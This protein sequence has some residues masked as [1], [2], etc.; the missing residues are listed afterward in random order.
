MDMDR[1]V[2]PTAETGDGETYPSPFYRTRFIAEFLLRP[3][4]SKILRVFVFY[5]RK[6]PS[7]RL[8]KHKLDTANN[9]VISKLCV[10][11]VTFFNGRKTKEHD[12]GPTDAR[13]S[14]CPEHPSERKKQPLEYVAVLG[15]VLNLE[16]SSIAL[17]KVADHRPPSRTGSTCTWPSTLKPS[18]SIPRHVC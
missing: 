3:L 11:A 12:H 2:A 13:R 16:P 9:R 14:S 7:W 10:T 5:S 6:S 15:R 18:N 1:L 17:K 4:R 8:H